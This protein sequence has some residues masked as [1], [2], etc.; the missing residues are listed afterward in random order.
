[1]CKGSKEGLGRWKKLGRE[2]NKRVDDKVD[3]AKSC[4]TRRLSR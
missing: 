4:S 1:M 2:G 3:N